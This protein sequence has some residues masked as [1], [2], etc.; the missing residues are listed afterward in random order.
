MENNNKDFT[1]PE[2]KEQEGKS[3][4][5]E[6][7]AVEGQEGEQERE[8]GEDKTLREYLKESEKEERLQQ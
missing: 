8:S 6:Q 7:H 2:K 5:S 1:A 4:V 3:S